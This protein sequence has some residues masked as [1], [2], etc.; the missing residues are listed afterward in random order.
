MTGSKRSSRKAADCF[1]SLPLCVTVVLGAMEGGNSG[2]AMGAFGIVF[3]FLGL[4][5]AQQHLIALKVAIGVFAL[6]AVLSITL[7][8]ES[9]QANFNF[10]VSL[11]VKFVLLGGM[12]SG[13][14]SGLKLREE[15]NR[16]DEPQ[17]L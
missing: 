13:L 17:E 11:P 6:D 5:V 1:S 12:I 7:A 15:R 10:I 3:F 16:T 2:L 8:F 4:L 9:R 14:R